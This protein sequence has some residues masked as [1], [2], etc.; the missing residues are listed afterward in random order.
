MFSV[1]HLYRLKPKFETEGERS[2][3]R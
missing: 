1:R 3:G 2:G